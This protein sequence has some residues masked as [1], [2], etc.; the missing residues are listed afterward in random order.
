MSTSTSMQISHSDYMRAPANFE[1]FVALLGKGA[2]AYVQ[3]VIIAVS[4]SDELMKC[5]NNS[6]QRAALRAA[7][8]G[9]S[10]DPALKQAWLIPFPRKVK[11]TKDVPEHWIQEAQFLPHY[12]GFHT[13]AMR[14][15]KYYIIN[16]G[17]VYEGQHVLENPLTG[18]HVVI[19]NG[20]A[21]VPETYNRAYAI[22]HEYADWSDVTVRRDHNQMTIGWM[23]YFETRQG[24]KKSVYMSCEEI[25]EHA[26]IYVKGY[27]DE[28]GKIKPPNWRDPT[29]RPIMEMK[30]VF[31]QLMGWADLSG[32]ENQLLV[33]ALAIESHSGEDIAE[34]A[35]EALHETEWKN[36]CALADK[37]HI[38]YDANI[39]GL[40]DADLRSRIDQLL[41]IVGDIEAQAKAGE[42]PQTE[43]GSASK[44]APAVPASV[45]K[46]AQIPKERT[47][48][49]QI[50]PLSP[51]ALKYASSKWGDTTAQASKQIK[52]NM[53]RLGPASKFKNP[54]P[55]QT[56]KDTVEG[57]GK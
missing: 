54:M 2:N 38:P 37:N 10:C 11:A 28:Q 50:D 20:M 35:T 48:D 22:P 1:H 47:Q 9:L 36:A 16:V 39:K 41:V 12:R 30:T 33:E 14:T 52:D 46:P 8:L 3:S 51:E 49:V 34:G 26:R 21:T 15:N 17:P 32:R 56:F 45:K 23:A 57:F 27:L 4:T 19:Q 42:E 13:L 44:P 29:K 55:K 6:I 5:T 18:L 43:A 25:E 53:L 7:S 40:S 24:F 31:R